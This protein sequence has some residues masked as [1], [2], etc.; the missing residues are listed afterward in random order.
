[1]FFINT[2]GQKL[3][4]VNNILEGIIS[5]LAKKCELLTKF[6]TFLDLKHP[7]IGFWE[8]SSCLF[9]STGYRFPEKR[10]TKRI[11]RD[12]F[13][14]FTQNTFDVGNISVHL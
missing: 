6:Y 14:H 7:L 1:M 9:K 13:T 8:V 4:S 3:N 12:S 2:N 5:K 10:K 11:P